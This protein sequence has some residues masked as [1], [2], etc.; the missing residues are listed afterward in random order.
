MRGSVFGC[1][2]AVLAFAP[3]G[4]V[5]AQ[6]AQACEKIQNSFQYNE[7]LAKSAPPRAQRASRGGGDP[8]ASVPARRRGAA[9]AAESNVLP[10][11]TITRRTG[12]RVSATIDPWAGARGPARKRRR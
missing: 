1:L 9:V 5:S 3:F 8:E 2:L 10:G 6:N 12:R 7:C 11:M 4:Q